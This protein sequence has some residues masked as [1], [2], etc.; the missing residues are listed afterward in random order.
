MASAKVESVQCGEVKERVAYLDNRNERAHEIVNEFL[1]CSREGMINNDGRPVS[2]DLGKR[3]QF[4]SR[5]KE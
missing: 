3:V 2:L 4:Q 5:G 1:K